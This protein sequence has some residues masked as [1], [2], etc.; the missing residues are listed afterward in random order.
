MFFPFPGPALHP[1]PLYAIR[2]FISL[3]YPLDI[4]FG[5]PEAGDARAYNAGASP[6]SRTSDIHAICRSASAAKNFAVLA[7]RA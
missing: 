7:R 1:P 6:P 5:G 2:R 4:R 3:D